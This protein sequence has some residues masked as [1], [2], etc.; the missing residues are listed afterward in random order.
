MIAATSYRVL[1][2]KYRPRDFAGLIG[3]EAMV[4][5]L[6]NAMESGRLAHAFVLTGVRGI[7]K[8]TTARIIARA[9]N[10]ETGPTT[11]P[12]GVCAHCTAIDEDRHVDVLEMDAASH[13]GV[14]DV[15]EILDGVR[16]RPTSAR[17]KIYII[18][19]VHMLS[20]AAFNALLKTLEEPPEHT[21]FVFA[22]TEI[23]KMPV[24][25]LSR[26]QRFDLRRVTEEDLAAHFARLLTQEQAEATPEA[27][28]ILARA[29]DGSVRDGLSL[30]DQAL[31]LHG[32][33]SPIP[34]EVVR[35]ML[36]LVDRSVVFD[37]LDRVFRGDMAG[38]LAAVAAQYQAGGDPVYI[39]QELL[40]LVHWLTR[41][42]VTPAAADDAAVPQMER[43]Q[44][45]AMA[46][47]LGMP[48][49]TRAWQM[50][51]KGLEEVRMA[52]SPRQA[53]EMVLVRLAFAADLPSPAE[54]LDALRNAPTPPAGGG[55]G[56]GGGGAAGG[57]GRARALA[58]P[59]PDVS[60]ETA[61]RAA[62]PTDFPGV[63]AVVEGAREA[64]LA[65]ALVH[66][67]RL[68]TFAPGRLEINPGHQAPRDLAN[69]L[70]E[71]LHQQTGQRWLVSV[72]GEG[73]APPLAEQRTAAAAQRTAAAEADP[74]VQAILGAFP[75]ARVVTV[76]ETA[77]DPEP[78]A[79][80]PL[81]DETDLAALDA[82]FDHGEDD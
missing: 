35:E 81:G 79:G 39:T 21:K 9:L 12:C 55:G 63:V 54:A 60:P 42:K 29:A 41:L 43:E 26:C 58:A 70:G 8:T 76:R 73:G 62:M 61:P 82:G 30:L 72:S 19:E 31:A 40:E 2:R 37:L 11:T 53:L 51:L 49:L 28:A 74:L 27:L 23:R 17:Y 18:D 46:E 3:Q 44:G 20:N 65:A 13:T 57:G 6:T 77:R 33:Q 64:R 5:T 32:T 80:I 38:A 69:R 7:G 78:T 4:R 36:G 15:R 1:A 50:L 34:P 56:H 71:V 10:C 66:D 52:P 45:R 25:V 16:Y 14:N 75:K 67:V 59:A 48:V 24:T 22:T 68:V 47:G